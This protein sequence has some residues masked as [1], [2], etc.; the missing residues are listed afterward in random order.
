MSSV[1]LVIQARGDDDLEQDDSSEV[2]K[3]LSREFFG[4]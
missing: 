1:M 2:G 4:R 3:N